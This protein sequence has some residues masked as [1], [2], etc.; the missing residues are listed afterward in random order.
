MGFSVVSPRSAPGAPRRSSEATPRLV[1]ID[2]DTLERSLLTPR[3]GVR[4]PLPW[5]LLRQGEA[6]LEIAQMTF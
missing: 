4:V 5:P 6:T 1:Q 3:A 2:P